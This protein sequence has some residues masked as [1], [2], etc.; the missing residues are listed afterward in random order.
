MSRLD[1]FPPTLAEAHARIAAVRPAD[2]ARTRNALDGCVTG[3][4]PYV[5]HGFVDLPEIAAGVGAVHAL[6]PQH[7][8]MFELGWRE[9]FRH[10]W[11]HRGNRIFESA[12][13]GPLPDDAYA[14]A[15]PADVREA[16][17]GVPVIDIAVRTLYASGYLHNHAR[18]WLASY[19]VHV[20]RV[21][22]R[23]GADWL[24]AHL[25]D[26]DL[27]SN[28][29]SWQWVAGTFSHKPYLFN[30]DNV[31]RFA[32]GHW[33]SP[34]SVIDTSYEA[35]DA[36]ARGGRLPPARPAGGGVEAPVLHRRPPDAMRAV[37]ADAALVADR[38]VWLIHPWALHEP[39][40]D[41]AANTL[42][43][44][45]C[46][47][48]FH[49]TWPWSDARWNFVGTGMDAL[50][51]HCWHDSAAA[52]DAALRTARSVRYVGDAHLGDGFGFGSSVGPSA[53]ACPQALAATEPQRRLF[54]AVERPCSSFSQW[55]KKA[56][57][58]GERS[59]KTT[60]KAT[61]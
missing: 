42:R 50:S 22:W 34:G 51:S 12:H 32:P 61:R 54:A 8:L 23:A 58:T 5:T 40:D 52:I 49:E 19:L 47:A 2:Y 26:G 33:H 46:P 15:L 10:V 30:A 27:G 7:K 31:A 4:S 25:L 39:P 13:A 56:S 1:F 3:L 17:T 20:R 38:D 28:H 53:D 57:P 24:Y 14:A 9:F 55:W 35:L 18:M 59:D 45:I 60:T 41:L 48:E 43:V 29:L 11:Q 36:I 44:S 21:H 16:R 6:D 37:R